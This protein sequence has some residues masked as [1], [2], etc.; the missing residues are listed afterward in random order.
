VVKVL[1]DL[2]R[3]LPVPEV[4]VLGICYNRVEE[5]TVNVISVVGEEPRDKLDTAEL[6]V[7]DLRVDDKVVLYLGALVD[8]F[9]LAYGDILIGPREPFGVSRKS[10][11]HIA[12]SV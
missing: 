2:V 7:K 12:T 9:L 4:R 3:G 1:E 8:V 6:Y 10:A 5:I 11:G